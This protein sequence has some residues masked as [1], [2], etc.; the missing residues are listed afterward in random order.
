MALGMAAAVWPALAAVWLDR[1][2]DAFHDFDRAADADNHR[3]RCQNA[4]DAAAKDVQRIHAFSP[5]SADN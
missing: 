5:F 4:K 2:A 1:P 3:A